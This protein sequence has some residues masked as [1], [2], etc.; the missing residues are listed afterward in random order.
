MSVV[1]VSLGGALMEG[2]KEPEQQDAC[3]LAAVQ[4]KWINQLS[5]SFK[6]GME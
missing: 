4:V 2:L 3:D 5:Q 1:K 6:I